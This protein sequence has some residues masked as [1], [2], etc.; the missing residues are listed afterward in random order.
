MGQ[1]AVPVFVVVVVVV[2]IVVAVF[3][4]VV[5]VF[6]VAVVVVVFLETLR[7][8]SRRLGFLPDRLFRERQL[9]KTLRRRRDGGREEWEGGEEIEKWERGVESWRKEGKEG[10]RKRWR[11]LERE[12]WRDGERDG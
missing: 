2:I 8:S 5:A 9:R 3:V 6:Y 1:I 7:G 11:D 10:W 4:V 12:R